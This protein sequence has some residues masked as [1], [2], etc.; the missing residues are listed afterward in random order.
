MRTLLQISLAISLSASLFAQAPGLTGPPSGNNQKASV[1]QFIGPVK[2]SIDYSSPAVR[3]R[4]GQI[5]GKL[6]P[7]GMADL[8]VLG[9]KLSP[10]RGGANEN[11]V[12]TIS[13][14]VTIEGQTLPAGKYGL[15]F[16]PGQDEWT[17]IFS[18]DA[19]AWGSFF[20]DDSHDALRVKVKPAKHEYREWLTYE[21]PVRRPAEAT[22]EL[23]WEEL[24]V[25][26]HIKVDNVGDIYVTKIRQELKG[27]FGFNPKYY[28]AAAQICVQEGT[29]LEDAL[30]WAD[31]A[32]NNPAIGQ[33][34]FDTLS[35]KALVLSKMGRDADAQTIMQTAL[36]HPT[37]SAIQIHTYGR[38]LLTAGKKQE[39]LDVF[40]LNAERNGDAWPVNVGL[41]RG[42]MAVGDYPKALEYA[43]K[44][45][46]QAPD[47]Q[48]KSNLE[49]MV[50]SLA[51]GKAYA[52]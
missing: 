14:P 36:R 15:H 46:A 18:K 40:K 28:D 27:S 16:I 47:N 29:H 12:F 45:V 24:S 4:R 43:Q 3:D 44:A 21:S 33:T 1:T 9:G 5:W 25:P 42:Y 6:V 13:D 30:N 51:D 49:A 41:A 22:A 37:A 20:Y 10:W 39:A 32:I 26:W 31:L 35:T 7:Y 8:G 2:I 38:Q 17:I 52:N 50:K 11:T 19:E 48:N 34:N 23:Q